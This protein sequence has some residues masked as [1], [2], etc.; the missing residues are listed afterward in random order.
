MLP[1]CFPK[2]LYQFCIPANYIVPHPH[3]HLVLSI[4]LTSA[5]PLMYDNIS[6]CISLITWGSK[7]FFPYVLIGY[8][9]LW[10]TCLHL[11]NILH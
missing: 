11:L 9:Y 10:G 4:F 2:Y 6:F 1:Y 8:F 5:I 7:H 3:Q